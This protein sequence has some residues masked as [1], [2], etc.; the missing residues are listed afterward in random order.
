MKCVCVCLCFRPTRPVSVEKLNL[1][2]KIPARMW[3][4]GG[5]TMNDVLM[6]FTSFLSLSLF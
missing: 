6:D 3:A 1:D 5:S 2:G 4:I